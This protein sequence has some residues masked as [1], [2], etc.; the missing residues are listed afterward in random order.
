VADSVGAQHED[1]V[2]L[3]NVDALV[4]QVDGHDD[5]HRSGAQIPHRGFTIRRGRLAVDRHGSPTGSDEPGGEE[6]GVVDGARE[7]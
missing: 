6:P 1:R 5:L 3:G 7:G 4:E 2:D